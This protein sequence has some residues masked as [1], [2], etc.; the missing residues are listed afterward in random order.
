MTAPPAAARTAG[1]DQTIEALRWISIVAVVFHH[2][3]SVQRQSPETI[4]QIMSF[5]SWIEWCVPAFFYL[6]GRLFRPASLAGLPGALSARARRLLVPYVLVSLL[7]FAALAI[8]QW[9]HLW[10][11]PSPEEL[12]VA[13]LIEKLVWLAGFGPQLYFLPYLFLVGAFA[14]ALATSIPARW[15]STITGIALLVVGFGWMF[16]DTVL[17]PGLER[18][19]IFLYCYCLGA[20]DRALDALPARIHLAATTVLAVA[21]ALVLSACWPLSLAVPPLL[22]RALRRFPTTPAVRFLE[23]FGKPGGIFLWHAPILLPACSVALGILHV[24]D[25]ANYILSVLLAC[26][27]ALVVDR[28]VARIPFLRIARL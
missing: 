28:I 27:A 11:S 1:R 25:W 18:L 4:E 6:S 19:A 14:S 12:R 17:G 10:A 5:R 24:R 26:I 8:L 7:S 22:Y 13:V 15:L 21:L 9:S 23:N 2:G 3:I 20:S 16:P